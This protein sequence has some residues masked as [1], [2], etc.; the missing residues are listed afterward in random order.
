MSK[1]I[2]AA[3]FILIASSAASAFA[4]QTLSVETQI[5]HG[6]IELN[7]NALGCFD[8]LAALQLESDGANGAVSDATRRAFR[9]GSCVALDMGA[10]VSGAKTIA[11]GDQN[12]LRGHVANIIT[13][14]PAWNASI[15]GVDD[16]YDQN[17]AT[18]TSELRDDAA[19]LREKVAAFEACEQEAAALNEMIAGYNERADEMGEGEGEPTTGS[20]L[21]GGTAAPLLQ[22]RLPNKEREVLYREGV[23]LA[24]DVAAHNIRCDPF[25]EGFELDQDYLTFFRAGG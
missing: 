24:E 13:Y 2:S 7:K 11:I 9:V 18:A 25:R 23:E 5:D 22:I 19:N 8:P 10:T 16:S 15:A 12:F 3:A 17:A 6:D 21:S 1:S 14:I 20:R 4:Q